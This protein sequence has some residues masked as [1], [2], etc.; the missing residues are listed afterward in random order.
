MCF[1]AAN[2]R[3]VP[4][5]STI[6]IP[7][8][9]I[10]RSPENF[11]DPDTF[12]PERF[13]NEEQM[14]QKKNPFTYLP[15]SAGSRNCPGQKFAMYEMKCIISKILLNFEISLSKG[16][17]MAPVLSAEIV[18]RPENSIKFNLKRRI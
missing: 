2:N 4:K 17:E 11:D 18:L 1:Y 3:M 14:M 12:K 7:F 9:S 13:S 15:F 8:C 16:S 10:N 6:L 5:G